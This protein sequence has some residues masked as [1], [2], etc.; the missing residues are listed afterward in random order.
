M[1]L[2]KLG[3]R[4][5][6][7]SRSETEFHHER[8]A[9]TRKPSH[10]K[11]HM[12]RPRY[13]IRHLICQ[14]IPILCVLLPPSGLTLPPDTH[15]HT[16]LTLTPK[17]SVT[18]RPCS[19]STPKDRLSSRKIRTLYWYFSFTWRETGSQASTTTTL[20][21]QAG[22]CCTQQLATSFLLCHFHMS[23]EFSQIEGNLD[24]IFFF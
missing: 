4:G 8:D 12:Q 10:H 17:C 16:K 11:T 23:I 2:R 15:T 3:V 6:L 14:C 18:P 21:Q 13:H 20:Q 5:A 19:P 22:P 7:K 24:Y 9:E 1:L